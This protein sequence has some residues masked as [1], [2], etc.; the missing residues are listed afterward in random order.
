MKALCWHGKNDVRVDTVPD[1]TIQE[2]RDAVVKVTTTAICGSDLHLYDGYIPTMESGDVLGHEFIG[3]VVALGPDAKNLKVGDRVLVPFCIACGECFFCQKELWSLCGHSNPNA[4]MAEEVYGHSPGGLFG[5][6]HLMG[7]YA[8]GQA[9]YVRV[10]F[11]DVGA[12]SVPQELA[13]EQVLFLT[14]IL[15]TAYMAAE[16]AQIEPGS[17]VAVWGC[18]PVG[19]LTIKCAF[20]LGAGRVIAVDNVDYRLRMARDRAGAETI[21]FDQVEVIETLKEMTDGRGPDS[22][23]DC[24]GLEAHGQSVDAV[25]DRVKAALWLATDRPHALREAIQVCRKGGTVSVPGVYGGFLDKLNFG[26]AFNKGLT[27]KMGQTHVHRY[28]RPLME[29]IQRLEIDP[30]FIITHRLP[31]AEAP[32]GYETFKQRED[33]CVK[34]VMKP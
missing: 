21:N 9:E 32:K 13:D 7:G 2:P 26:A 12:F 31:L 24:V 19:Q 11:A 33:N 15:P 17:T 28:V 29:R 16:N 14:D 4:K 34:V 1:A 5:Y 6:S 30:T 10:P 23:I 27:L 22:C 20:L 18:G 25:Y 3:E 8:G